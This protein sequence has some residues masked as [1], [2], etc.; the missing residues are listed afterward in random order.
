VCRQATICAASILVTCLRLKRVGQLALV[1][2]A[3]S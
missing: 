2:H 3:L 1:V